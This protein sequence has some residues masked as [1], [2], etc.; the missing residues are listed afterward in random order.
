MRAGG[1]APGRGALKTQFR[2]GTASA[3]R[4]KKSKSLKPFSLRFTEEERAR[5]E[6][7][8]GQQSLASYIRARLLGDDVSPRKARHSRKPRRP[9]IDHIALGKV[10]GALG[11]SRLASNMNQIA[12]AA[13]MGALP[14]T[15][16]LMQE[17]HEA[18]A[19][20]RAM[21]RDLIAALG[22]KPEGGS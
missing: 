4:Q 21:R 12:K 6:R 11:Q 2:A 16:D 17:L 15:P 3:T 13:H 18:C 8:A 5:L 22:I 1:G 14:V 7:A 20:I 9:R 19:A 10:L